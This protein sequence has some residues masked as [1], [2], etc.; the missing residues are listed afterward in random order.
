MSANE[1]I[2]QC[3]NNSLSIVDFTTRYAADF[4]RLNVEWITQHWELEDA[5]RRVLDHPEEHII[6]RGGAIFIALHNGS[7]IGTVALLAKPEATYELAKMAVSPT[8]QGQGFGCAIA[9]H[10]LQR[11]REMGARRVYLE[12]NTILTPAISLYRKLGFSELKEGDD[13]SPYS[14]CNIQMEKVF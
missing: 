13:S 2:D 4:K 7:P 6:A 9:E 11:A 14:R 8:V 1:P 12:S 5:D 3:G 10:A